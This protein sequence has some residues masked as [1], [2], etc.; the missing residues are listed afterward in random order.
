MSFGE[1]TVIGGARR[2]GIT[3]R[4]RPY[5]SIH[6]GS[7]AVYPLEIIAAYSA[8]AT[9]GTRVSPQFILRVKD[10]HGNILWQPAQQ[11]E[12]IMDSE[13]AWLMLD[14]MRD[15]VRRGTAYGAVWRAGF[16]YPSAG[17]T[18]TTDD[19]TDAWYVGFTSE[20][21]SGVWIGYD[22]VQRVMNNG[23]GGL[24]SYKIHLRI[25]SPNDS[26]HHTSITECH[27]HR[28][29]PIDDVIVATIRP[30]APT[31]TPVPILRPASMRTTAGALVRQLG[32]RLS[33][34]FAR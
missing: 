29:Q 28:P 27:A 12:S 19:Y 4:I 11:R 26:C 1:Q 32:L 34:D 6:I 5:P 9:M 24:Y 18:G 22:L 8:F 20:I 15:V 23:G 13:H 2:F 7:E 30:S 31:I 25:S 14:M 33:L 3:T 16:T 10:R 21:V 17:K